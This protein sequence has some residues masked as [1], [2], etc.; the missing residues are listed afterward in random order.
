MT[1]EQTYAPTQ[2]DIDNVAEMMRL[3][4]EAYAHYFEHESHCKSSEGTVQLIS[5]TYWEYGQPWGCEVYSYVLG[6]HRNHEFDTT[7]AALAA[8]RGWHASEM[9]CVCGEPRPSGEHPV[10]CPTCDGPVQRGADLKPIR[11]R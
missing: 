5:P 10:H 1:S 11:G 3:M 8:V 4:A 9:S 2:R 6:P 7:D